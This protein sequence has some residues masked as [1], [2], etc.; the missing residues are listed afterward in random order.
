VSQLN[1]PLRKSQ[2]QIRYRY[3]CC[4]SSACL[5]LLD[6]LFCRDARGYILEHSYLPYWLA[7]GKLHGPDYTGPDEATVEP[8]QRRFQVP[9]FSVDR[10]FLD[11]GYDYRAELLRIQVEG[12]L[13]GW[14]IR[15]VRAKNAVSLGSPDGSVRRNIDILAAEACQPAGLLQEWLALRR[16]RVEGCGR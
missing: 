7:I 12:L 10:S 8:D 5:G 14:A 13:R 16:S 9:A 1:S 4:K 3:S 15:Q 6:S 2:S 11:G